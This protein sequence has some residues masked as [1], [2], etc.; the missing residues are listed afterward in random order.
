MRTRA[1]VS[2]ASL[3]PSPV[4]SLR[5]DDRNQRAKRERNPFDRE[6]PRPRPGRI[7][8]DRPGA[9]SPAIYAN[10]AYLRGLGLRWDPVGHRWHGTTTADRVKTLREQLGLEARCFGTLK[11]PRGPRPP[12]PTLVPSTSPQAA[13]DNE[14]LRRLHDG[15]RTRAE[16]R[17]VYYADEEDGVANSRFS[18]RDITSGL[19][20]DSREEDEKQVERCV[21]DL[22]ARVKV[23]RAAVSTTPGLTEILASDWR[24]AARFYARYGISEAHFRHGV[25]VIDPEV[26]TS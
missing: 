13:R 12:A 14:H 6:L 22:R 26:E 16:A 10:R 25:A 18:E 17:T 8:A 4:R 5:A 7:A 11:P 1:R 15:S 19:P 3:A 21:R 24:K 9:G 23:A 20:D 2:L